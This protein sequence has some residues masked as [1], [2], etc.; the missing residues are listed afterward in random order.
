MNIKPFVFSAV[1]LIGASSPI[2]QAAEMTDQVVASFDRLLNHTP[3]ATAVAAPVA[4]TVD[5]DPLRDNLN[6]VL[7][8]SLP[9]HLSLEYAHLLVQTQP[10]N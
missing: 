4:P 1:V 6:A 10:Q 7:W 8:T 3:T 9:Y 5:A 2:A